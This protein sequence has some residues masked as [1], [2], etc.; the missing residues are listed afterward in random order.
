MTLSER[1]WPADRGRGA[2]GSSA[3]A[4]PGRVAPLRAFAVNSLA[5]GRLGWQVLADFGEG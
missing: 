4:R 5:C 3:F 2:P 1:Q